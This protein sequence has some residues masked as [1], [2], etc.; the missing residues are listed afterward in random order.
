MQTINTIEDLK[1]A[2][3]GISVKDYGDFKRKT[4]L[5][6]NRFMENH[7]KA[8]EEA[9]KKIDFMKWCI[10]F[11]PN[12]DLKTTRLWTLAQLDELKGALGQ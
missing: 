10:Q 5:Y 4:I 3:Q 7:E 9:Q 6:L 12:L 2:V 11:H 8:P 1:M